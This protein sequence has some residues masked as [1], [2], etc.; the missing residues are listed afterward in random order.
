[1][2]PLLLGFAAFVL[3]CADEPGIVLC[4]DADGFQ[5]DDRLELAI[6]FAESAT[7]PSCD[8]IR[9]VADPPPYCVAATRGRQYGYAMALR[10]VW[11]RGSDELGRREV[12]VPFEDGRIV[13]GDIIVDTCC[14]PSDDAHQCV[15]G[16]CV[17]IRSTGFLDALAEDG[18]CL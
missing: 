8:P 18:E 13:E 16:T 15:D 3:S 14:A 12:T 1:M 4:L 10:A 6:S 11:S 2:R 9:R 5:A 7:G 17:L